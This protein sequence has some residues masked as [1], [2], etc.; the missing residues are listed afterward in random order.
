VVRVMGAATRKH[1][2]GLMGAAE[3]PVVETTVDPRATGAVRVKR[4]ARLRAERQR[5]AADQVRVVA[6]V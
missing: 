5:R 3:K 2:N 4:A 6:A 1:A